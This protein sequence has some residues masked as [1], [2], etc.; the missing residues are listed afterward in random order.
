MAA[1]VSDVFI[2]YARSTEADA[3]RIAEALRGLGYSVWRDD[4]LPAHRAYAE[5]IE[6]RLRS[7][8]AVLVVWSAEAV[9]SEWVQSEADHARLE[10]KLVQLSVDGASP[11]MPFDRIQ[12]A[13]L[14]GWRR[15]P[16]HAGWR[17]VLESLAAL[18]GGKG[19]RRERSAPIDLGRESDFTLGVANIHPSISEVAVGA[20][21]IRL[22]PR[23]MQV[24]VALARAEG[25]AVSRD[26]LIASCWGGLAIGDD[27][28]N[29]CIGRLRRLSETE[30][31]GAFTIET[32][33][34][35]G[36]RLGL[37][38]RAAA[39]IAP[40]G[41]PRW[42]TNWRMGVAGVVT[43]AVVVAAVVWFGVGTSGWSSRGQGVAVMPFETLPGDVAAREFADGVAD[44]VA[45]SLAKSDLVSVPASSGEPRS[46]PERDALSRRLGAAYT[47]S[48]HVERAGASLVVR[49]DIDEAQRH[50]R[51]WSVDFTRDA[52]QAQDLQEEVASK[53][54]NVLHCALAGDGRD[55]ARLDLETARLYLSACDGVAEEESSTRTRDLFR[56]VVARNP[57]FAGG[58]ARFALASAFASQELAG[59]Q[60]TAAAS[61]AR[62]AASRALE[63]DPKAG[64][65]YAALET[66]APQT[67]LAQRQ[68]LIQKGLAVAPDIAILNYRESEIM[69][70]VG[71]VQDQIAYNGR[72]VALD[73]LN[74]F[75]AAQLALT[76]TQ[77]DF[78]AQGRKMLQ[79]DA[80]IWPHDD[81]IKSF[82]MGAEAR[83][84]DPATALQLL[85]DPSTL[86]VMSDAQLADWRE[87]ALLRQSGDKAKVAA[88]VQQVLVNVAGKRLSV[89]QALVRFASLGA[90]DA[91]FLVASRATPDDPVET[92]PFFRTAAAPLRADSRFLPLMA[93]TGV[94]AFW[95][96]TG[97]WADF[98]EQA[99]RPYDCRAMA[100]KL[101]L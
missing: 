31:P 34:R 17:K 2:S 97:K 61:E 35:I 77:H 66:L 42:L 95:R 38:G 41:L 90:A 99:D 32:L 91:A 50:E 59:D 100:A 68:S 11:P 16:A 53:V 5:V 13:D 65:A 64:L 48:G 28:I 36:Y 54:A 71:R 83:Y 8:K 9:R 87:F 30:A 47:L 63:L 60:A 33:P 25:E 26:D 92:E 4:Q 80:R 85:S 93:K 6:E 23:V 14:R 79:R 82:R 81:T 94:I 88:Y 21:R 10:R 69:S 78:F 89:A 18:T 7:A 45:S 56:E 29:R 73:P 98:C 96:R 58:W 57:G 74:P 49:V 70:E 84:G 19:A 43:A 37:G 3:L 44:E 75:F 1:P 27:A 72:A 40:S 55:T 76:L 24:L 39:S 15:D 46:G 86:G 67:D 62:Q 22:Q 101:G 52:S 20:E 51:V 12:C